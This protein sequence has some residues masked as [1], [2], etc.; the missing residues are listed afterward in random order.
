MG[1][2]EAALPEA[3]PVAAPE[4]L[5]RVA[6][7]LLEAE[8]DDEPALPALVASWTVLLPHTFLSTCS[9][10]NCCVASVPEAEMQLLY[11]TRHI[12][13]GTVCWYWSM[14]LVTS[15]PFRHLHEYLSVDCTEGG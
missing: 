1:V 14:T 3:L 11:H 5:E 15:V 12:W 6:E 8:A 7:G 13:P 9:H 4:P 10:S 2:D